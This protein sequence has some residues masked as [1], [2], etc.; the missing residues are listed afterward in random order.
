MQEKRSAGVKPKSGVKTSG[1]S[2]SI[3]SAPYG[4]LKGTFGSSL[5]DYIGL[6]NL[7]RGLPKRQKRRLMACDISGCFHPAHTGLMVG[8]R[9]K[10]YCFCHDPLSP[11]ECTEQREQ[12]ER[13]SFMNSS[14]CVFCNAS[15]ARNPIHGIEGKVSFVCDKCYVTPISELRKYY[16]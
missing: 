9:T 14:D 1:G 4:D 3:R 15:H 5:P 12:R 11:G 13:R 6:T 2:E 16:K 8:G 7:D 10:W